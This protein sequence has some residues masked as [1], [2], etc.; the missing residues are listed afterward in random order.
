MIQHRGPGQLPTSTPV[1]KGQLLSLPCS[2]GSEGPQLPRGPSFNV[3]AYPTR[4]TEY[5]V[6]AALLSSVSFLTIP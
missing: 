1:P 6:S 5:P 2:K 4:P 3:L